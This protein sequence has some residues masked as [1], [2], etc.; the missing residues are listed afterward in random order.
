MVTILVYIVLLIALT[1]PLGAY[2]YRVYSRERIGRA[3]GLVYRLI[4]VNPELEQSW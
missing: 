2:M 1:P 4:G 3:E